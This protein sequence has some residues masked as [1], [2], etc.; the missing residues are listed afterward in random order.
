MSKLTAHINNIALHHSI[1]ALPFAYMGAFLGARG[2]PTVSE[3]LWITVAMVGARSAALA[4][5]NLVDLKYDKL[6]P[7]FTKRPMVTG[8][9]RPWEA[10][11]LIIVSL[12]VF[13]G[14]AAQLAPI[15]L[16][17]APIA[18]FPFVIYPYMK[19]YTFCCHLVL[20]LALSMAPFGGWVAVTGSL[21]LPVV[22]LGLAVGIW[23][24]AFDVI[25]G[26]QDEEFDRQHGLHSMATQFTVPGALRIAKA[27]HGVCIICFVMVGW[28][29]QL[30]PIYYVGVLVAAVTLIYQHSIVSAS[31]LSRVTQVYFMRNGIVAI[32]IFC[33]TYVSL[34]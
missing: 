9:V 7:R 17:V 29:M 28:L 21:S 22:M 31:D 15:C 34:G 24:A 13:L 8:E 33:F 5:D 27:M 26:C 14:A 30:S 2:V 25:Y 10:I 23:I 18:I 3:L 19:R 11:L 16:K 12:I 20:G 4:I 32:A 1:F 6:H